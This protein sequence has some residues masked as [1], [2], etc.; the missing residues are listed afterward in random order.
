MK[1]FLVG[2]LLCSSVFASE[3]EK[4]LAKK[5]DNYATLRKYYSSLLAQVNI[6]DDKLF[7]G[8]VFT[9][10]PVLNQIFMDDQ[11][12]I[13]TL[14]TSQDLDFR[15]YATI[16]EDNSS[17]P[18]FSSH[19][20]RQMCDEQNRESIFNLV[21][22]LQYHVMNIDYLSMSNLLFWQSISGQ[23]VGY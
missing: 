21:Q 3:V 8:Q 23:R 4:Q 15:E 9:T 2:L 12:L 13:K 19:A 1:F 14:R 7:C 16:I 20:Y 5:S 17:T 11:A 10:V 6:Q 22:S 18:L